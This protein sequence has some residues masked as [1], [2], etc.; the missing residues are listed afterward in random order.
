MGYDEFVDACPSHKRAVY[1]A[2]VED[3]K[4]REVSRSD[5]IWSTFIKAEKM[6][7]SLKPDPVP[8]MINPRNPRYNVELGRYI[9]PAEHAIYRAIDHVFGGRVVAK[10]KNAIERASMLR[11]AWDEFDNP[12]AIGV[13]ASRFDEHVDADA[14]EY[15]HS[16]YN[17]IFNDGFLARLLT[18]QVNNKGYANFKDG[19]IKFQ[20]RGTRGSGDMNTSLG[21]VILMCAMLYTFLGTI[22]G[23][24]RVI[25]DGDDAV[26]IIEAEH[27]DLFYSRAK[28]FFRRLGFKLKYESV[29]REFELIEF[30]QTQPVYDGSHWVMC[31]DPRLVIDKDLCSIRGFRNEKEW[32]SLCSAVGE[33]GLALAGN[34]PVFNSFYSMLE[35]GGVVHRRAPTG[36]DFLARRMPNNKRRPV[37]DA[38]RVSFFIAFGITPDEQIALEDHYDM[39]QTAWTEPAHQE[40]RK[41]IETEIFERETL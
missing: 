39:I 36:M 2:S 35:M 28:P 26:V 5:A 9:K 1:R 34:L 41:N 21:N 17:A 25:D 15:E 31:R 30:C 20:I 10:G 13:D 3:L 12:V 40:I 11:E 6:N 24:Y 16:I 8:R 29:A 4:V 33:C 22:V 37:N 19:S 27:L 38:A 18:W 23:H 7:L 32:R 14:L